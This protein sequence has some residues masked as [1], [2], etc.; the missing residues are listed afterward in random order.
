[1]GA[2]VLSSGL[3]GPVIGDRMGFGEI[4][5][6]SLIAVLCPIAFRVLSEVLILAFPRQD[7]FLLKCTNVPL[8]ILP[9]S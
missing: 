2:L 1:M 4:S 5:S 3:Q 6:L 9:K 7:G 8:K